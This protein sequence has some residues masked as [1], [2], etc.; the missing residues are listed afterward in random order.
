MY[1]YFIFLIISVSFISRE[2]T[3]LQK[4]LRTSTFDLKLLHKLTFMETVLRL[5]IEINTDSYI[6]VLY[7]RQAFIYYHV[8]L[9][10]TYYIC[11]L[12]FVWFRFSHA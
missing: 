7:S 10:I 8:Q 5:V 3:L 4:R 1:Y 12:I 6:L 11:Y 9:S 2:S